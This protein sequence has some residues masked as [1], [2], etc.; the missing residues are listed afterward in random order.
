[1]RA[2]NKEMMHL[3]EIEITVP[4]ERISLFF[5]LLAGGIRLQVETHRSLQDILCRQLG[6]DDDYLKNHIQTIF[7]NGR[8]MDDPDREMVLDGSEIALSAAMPG[9][10]GAV[11]R[12][13]GRLSVFRGEISSGNSDSKDSGNRGTI[14]LK[15]FNRVAADLGV[16][17]LKNGIML[18]SRQLKRFLDRQA[19]TI[20][21]MAQEVTIDG[22]PWEIMK[23]EELP[24]SINIRLKVPQTA[25]IGEKAG[26]C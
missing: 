16:D 1:M 17:F 20:A 9:L 3:P 19:K 18:E 26:N 25:M 5:Q 22:K 15:L 24:D 13:G 7:L 2:Y 6:M 12:K 8:V 21:R 4:A 10:V 14:I 11:F 23:Y